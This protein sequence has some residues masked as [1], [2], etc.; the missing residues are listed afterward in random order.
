MPDYFQTLA[1]G[2]QIA[3]NGYTIKRTAE[4]VIVKRPV[5]TDDERER[6]M[7]AIRCALRRM[8]IA[9]A[10]AESNALV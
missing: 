9:Q 10:R 7:D 6:R 5:L 1:I 8:A 4:N 2:E 3:E